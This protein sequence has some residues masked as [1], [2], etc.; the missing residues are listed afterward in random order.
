MAQAKLPLSA[1]IICK[2]EAACIE[3]CIRSL[4]P[5]AEIVV[6]D[7]GSG[8][9]TLTVLE[10]LA[11]EGWPIR[12][13]RR[14]W[15]GFALQKQFALEQCTQP[16]AINI[17]ADERLDPDLRAALPEL[18]AA[19]EQVGGWRLTRRPYLLGRGYAPRQAHEG[20][21]LRLVRRAG[22]RYNTELLVHEAILVGGEVRTAPRG[23]L[24]HF[25]LFTVDEQ[26]V[27]EAKYAE[28]KV[29]QL[30][31]EGKRLRP[32]RLFLNPLVYFLRYYLVRRMFLCGIPGFIQAATGAIY[33]FLT[34]ARMYQVTAEARDTA[35]DDRRAAGL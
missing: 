4:G 9:S 11:A 13:F 5:C 10:K 2:N 27:K 26:M 33:T 6:V 21:M 25:R 35:E 31:G 30:L 29:R 34:E 8:D 3:N 1:F 16:W 14:D 28:L 22:A 17:D 20:R 7:S 19:P 15:P 12:L 24:L 32:V 18:L 23:T